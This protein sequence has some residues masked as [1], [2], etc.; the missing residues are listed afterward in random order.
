MEVGTV[1]NGVVVL[2]ASVRATALGH[3]DGAGHPES[4]DSI[5]KPVLL[6]ERDTRV[7]PRLPELLEVGELEV[8]ER[9]VDGAVTIGLEVVGETELLGSCGRRR[10][11]GGA[12]A[13]V[14]E[15]G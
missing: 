8:G 2:A 15:K 6:W 12:L 9:R 3:I 7:L 10:L 14:R 11:E 13:E 4:T 5:T 1:G